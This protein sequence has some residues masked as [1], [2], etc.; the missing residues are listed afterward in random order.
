[1]DTPK[2]FNL[3]GAIMADLDGNEINETAFYNPG[4]KLVIYE[5]NQ[6]KWESPSSF[7]PIKSMLIDDIVNESNAPRDVPVWPQS[8]L[9][10]VDDALFVHKVHI[11]ESHIFLTIYEPYC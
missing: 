8:V 7:G 1:M 4:R 5:A 9:F 10:S 6:Q 3:L 2:G 11:S